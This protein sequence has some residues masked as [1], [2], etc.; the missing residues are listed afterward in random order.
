MSRWRVSRGDM[1]LLTALVAVSCLLHFFNLGWSELQG[2]EAS[3]VIKAVQ[4]LYATRE[5]RLLGALFLYGHEPVRALLAVPILLVAGLNEFALR[6]PNALAG[7]ATTLAIAWLAR[8]WFHDRLTALTAAALYAGSGGALVNRL[9]MGVGPFVLASTLALAGFAHY[10]G[11]QSRRGLWLSASAYL[12]ALLSY[13]DAL[14]LLPGMVG[15]VIA[16]PDL[17]HDRSLWRAAV[18]AALIIGIFVS[19]W[20]VLP[21]IALRM[22]IISDASG[23]GLW[24]ILRRGTGGL[25]ED[26]SVGLRVLAFYNGPLHAGLM[27]FGMGLFLCR[28]HGSR[29]DRWMAA[30]ALPPLLYFSLIRQPTVHLLNFSPLLALLAGRG[31]AILGQWKRL[32]TIFLATVICVALLAGARHTLAM[33]ARIDPGTPRPTGWGL[34]HFQGLKAAGAFIRSRAEPCDL[35]QSPL[36]GYMVQ[37]YTGHR[38]LPPQTLHPP[39]RF[40]LWPLDEPAPGPVTPGYGQVATITLNGVPTLAVFELGRADGHYG[41]PIQ[42]DGREGEGAFARFDQLSDWL[43]AQWAGCPMPR[44]P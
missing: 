17:R 13:F 27:L 41:E 32:G 30:I 1:A 7:A 18:W 14:F 25:T 36:D 5:P 6:L 22:G 12:L 4:T 34:P 44:G 21:L 15:R 39:A 40:A 10:L 23:V 28:L 2:D 16:D 19:L 31:W 42:L 29:A 3:A 35:V 33:A 9:V 24:R 26:L 8:L 11:R 43:P 20:A 38:P 37:L